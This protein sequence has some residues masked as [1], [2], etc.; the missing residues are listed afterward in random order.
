MKRGDLSKKKLIIFDLDGTLI[1]SLPYHTLAFLKVAELHG[2]KVPY[3]YVHSLMGKNSEQIFTHLKKE[4]GLKGDFSKL[5]IERRKIYDKILGK[6]DLSIPG[7]LRTLQYFKNK[8]IKF[9]LATGSSYS[10]YVRSTTKQFRKMFTLASTVDDVKHGKPSPEQ[11]LYVIKKM[12]VKK[13]EVLAVG[14]SIY[15][16]QAAKSAGVE[17]VGV[18]TGFEKGKPLKRYRHLAIL[19][20]VNEFQKIL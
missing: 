6:K 11:M 20:S 13:Q 7:V 16:A 8:K 18:K 19:N 14:D 15:D 4:Y 9:V 17:F 12:K 3:K 5:R 1:N 2:V 10:S